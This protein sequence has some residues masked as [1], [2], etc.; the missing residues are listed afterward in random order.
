[1]AA[2]NSAT[3][4][5]KTKLH[6]PQLQL[7]LVQRTPLL[8]KLHAGLGLHDVCAPPGP[9]RKLTLVAAPAGFGKSTLVANWLALLESEAAAGEHLWGQSCWLA[10]DT[11]DDNPVRFLT[12]VLAAVRGIYPAACEN[13]SQVLQVL[14]LPGIE[15][16]AEL[17]VSELGELGGNLIFV[18]DD[19]QELRN[20]DVQRVVEVLATN[21]PPNLHLVIVSRLDPPLPLARLRV[22]KQITEVRAVDLRFSV[23]EAEDFFA[24]ALGA[25]LPQE[26]VRSLDE[27]AEGWV[28]GLR[29]AALSLQEGADPSALAS[30]FRGTQHHILDFL[31]E[32]VMAQQPP[33]V[34]EF[35]ACTAPLEMLCA[36]LCS[37]VLSIVA[38]PQEA[39]SRFVVPGRSPEDPL[40]IDSRAVLDYLDRSHLFVIPLDENRQWYRYH[41]LFRE[42]LLYWQGTR[43]TAEEI[44]AIN[45][46]AA[47]WYARNGHVDVAVRQL[48][49]A[50]AVEEAADLIEVNIPGS[51]GRA[52]WPMVQQLLT[53]LPEE[54][55]AQRPV[56]ILSRAWLM[57]ML[58]RHDLLPG[59][60]HQAETL[61]NQ[62]ELDHGQQRPPWLQGWV[63]AL[64][65][66]VHLLEWDFERALGR[67]EEAL[68][69]LPSGHVYVRGMTTVYYVVALQFL[70]RHNEALAYCAHAL[71]NEPLATQQ[72]I[73][74]APGALATNRGDLRGLLAAG[75]GCLRQAPQSS[76]S[77]LYSFGQLYLGIAAYE[78]NNLQAALG[79]F[80]AV[81]DDR[82]GAPIILLFDAVC[83]L[84]LT[85]QALGDSSG[86]AA[87]GA[88]L[89]DLASD[90]QNP[91][92]IATAQWFQSRLAL[93]RGSV[94]APPSGY[95]WCIGAAS[96]LQ[97]RWTELPEIT[98]ARLLVA[99]AS[100]SSLQEAVALLLS[101]VERCVRHSL[102]WRQIEGLAVLAQAYAAQGHAE[103]A[104]ETILSAIKLAQPQSFVRTFVDLGPSMANLLYSLTR[105]GAGS[106][107]I[108]RL[109]GAF[110]LESR[111]AVAIAAAEKMDDE[112]IEPL[113]EREVEVLGL[114]A[115]RLSDKEI[116]ERLRISPL[117]V[118]RHSVNLYQK[119]HVNSRRQAVS[120]AQALGLLRPTA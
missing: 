17:L 63:D 18:L 6:K 9:A 32:Q 51:L 108:G 89:L 109:L 42:M 22:Q 2:A 5:L 45:R 96:A 75:E 28:A 49:E 120:R 15:F 83:G 79:H 16:L 119:L 115:E 98:Y 81:Y 10:L 29:L 50:G 3:I 76:V 38:P 82:F 1:M 72:R 31:L 11:H 30:A 100:R 66:L 23:Q 90:L 92:T 101:F 57:W 26:T 102:H 112:I 35:L 47:G 110:P 114:L 70:G 12:Y 39:N 88:T 86:A 21:A 94:P 77:K 59:L 68:A 34:T 55:V 61:L 52:A 64:W 84:A 33:G 73:G 105:K 8:Q 71:A 104:Q 56:L 25:A 14:P 97:Y 117:T 48:L 106:D 44:K 7:D 4:L 118:R 36:P 111:N 13:L 41:H 24:R 60:L 53:S 103:L 78:Q 40:Q 87:W 37:E 74:I 80:T 62:A 46:Q 58:Q 116:A 113:S 91:Y 69:R 19:Y 67:G 43:Y 99:Q 27:R 20:L 85:H 95:T 65:C 54:L 107:Y 93:Q